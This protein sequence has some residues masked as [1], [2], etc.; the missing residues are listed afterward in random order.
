MA[1]VFSGIQPTGSP[2]LGNYVGATSRWA[3]DQ[4]PD[5]YFCVVDLHAITLPHDPT[6]LRART[7]DQAAWTLAAGLDPDVVTLFVQSQVPQHTTLS[8]ILECV[9]SMG[10]LGR[11]V[12]FKDYSALAA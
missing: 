4:Q 3:A 7:L 6:E 12:Q 8:W 1:R 9:A 5:Q 10:E 11:M 2:H